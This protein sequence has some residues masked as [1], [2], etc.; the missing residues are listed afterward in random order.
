MVCVELIIFS[1]CEQND[2]NLLG[3]E[4]GNIVSKIWLIAQQHVCPMLEGAFVSD[5]LGIDDICGL[6][7]CDHLCFQE[8]S[9]LF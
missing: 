1:C 3:W 7:K 9:H 2:D 5:K 4:C 8:V 6:S